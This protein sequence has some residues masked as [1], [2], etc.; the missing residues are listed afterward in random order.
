M[1]KVKPD[2]Q[3]LDEIRGRIAELEAQRADIEAQP[4]SRDEA[5]AALDR[6]IHAEAAKFANDLSIGSLLNGDPRA[7]LYAIGWGSQHIDWTPTLCALMPDTVRA[8]YV[9]QIDAELAER[10][11]LSAEQRQQRRAE[12]DGE[13][14]RLA[15]EEERIITA[16]QAR[17]EAVQR[18]GDADPRAVLGLTEAPARP[19]PPTEAP[20]RGRVWTKDPGQRQWED[21]Q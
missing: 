15:Q 1:A 16:M 19:A 9:D 5:L 2:H 17:G 7:R 6:W 13:L 4:V 18:R 14:F 10:E 20:S 11:P 12:I 3:R 8:Y 21:R